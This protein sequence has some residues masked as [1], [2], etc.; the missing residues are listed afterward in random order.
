MTKYEDIAY[1]IRDRIRTGIYEPNT[2]L[3]N[4]SEFVEEFEVSRMTIKKALN[5]LI[6]EGLINSL[7]GSG[8]R[9]MSPSLWGRN[10][11]T[12]DKMEFD[13]L[14]LPE[15]QYENLSFELLK[16][17]VQFPQA[18]TQKQLLIAKEQPV[19]YLKRRYSL[20]DQPYVYEELYIPVFL[21]PE[22]T[23]STIEHSIYQHI[24]N[25]LKLSI[26]GTNK[27][28]YADFANEDD[29][30]YLTC[31][32]NQPIL[33][34]EQVTYLKDGKPVEYSICR[35]AGKQRCITSVSAKSA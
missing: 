34:T 3:P 12:L 23:E 19:Y 33:V 18:T 17:E 31:A 13:K 8:T 32:E 21:V 11:T 2:L 5:L 9:V 26:G 6:S 29:H 24:A 30:L 10:V 25:T 7:R 16:F 35:S 14:Q 1:T 22:L 4:Q 27:N 28:I 20:N 15:D